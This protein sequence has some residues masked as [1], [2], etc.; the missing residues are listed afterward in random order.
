MFI[1]IGLGIF[2]LII[3]VTLWLLPL[4]YQKIEWIETNAQ[5]I[6]SDF[7]HRTVGN[8]VTYAK[9]ESQR[10]VKLTVQFTSFQN[11]SIT[12]TSKV[13]TYTK[14]RSFFEKGQWVTILYNK[15]KPQQFKLKYQI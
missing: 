11:K 5:I 12:V 6:E 4:K 2:F 13:W 3:L 14:N 8:E 9:G 1:F 10:R 7:S 15:K